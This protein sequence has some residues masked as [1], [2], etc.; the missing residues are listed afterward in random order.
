LGGGKGEVEITVGYKY[1][2]GL[3]MAICETADALLAI[4]IGEKSAWTGNVT[5]NTTISINKP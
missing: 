2:A 5:G 1:Y 4:S 3:H